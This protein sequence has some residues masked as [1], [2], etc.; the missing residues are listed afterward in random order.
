MVEKV[1]SVYINMHLKDIKANMHTRNSSV[2][3]TKQSKI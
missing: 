1:P 3:K 2:N